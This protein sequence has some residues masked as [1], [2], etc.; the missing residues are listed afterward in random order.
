MARLSIAAYTINAQ[1]LGGLSVMQGSGPGVDAT[2]T[3]NAFVSWASVGSPLGVQFVNNGT[4][5][6]LVTNGA[7][8][9]AA[10]VLVGRKG[11][12]P[13]GLPAFNQ[14]ATTIT[15]GA[16]V[17]VPLIIGPF[18]VQDFTQ[19][20]STQYGSAPGGVIGAGG[21]GYTC[22]DFTNTTTLTVRLCQLIPAVP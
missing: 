16:S 1:A 10:N 13:G 12:G 21:V 22:I 15:I 2:G 19:T 20:D 14:A 17:T 6:L 4:Q 8:P 7:T 9:T 11:G 3:G 18:S 5:F